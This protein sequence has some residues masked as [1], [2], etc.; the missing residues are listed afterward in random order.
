[1][2]C[3][4][5]NAQMCSTVQ[6]QHCHGERSVLKMA[7]FVCFWTCFWFVILILRLFQ[8][9]EQNKDRCL[10]MQKKKKKNENHWLTSTIRTFFIVWMRRKKT[11]CKSLR[12]VVGR[13]EWVSRM[14]QNSPTKLSL[15]VCIFTLYTTSTYY[16]VYPVVQSQHLS[17]TKSGFHWQ[18][19]YSVS[20]QLHHNLRQLYAVHGTWDIPSCNRTVSWKIKPSRLTGIITP[21]KHHT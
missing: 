14:I 2:V 8:L 4:C 9:R 3:P 5:W 11:T 12:C 20:T 15:S 7:C 17:L 16:P 21:R 19:R 1:M 13:V 10:L 18:Y 6:K